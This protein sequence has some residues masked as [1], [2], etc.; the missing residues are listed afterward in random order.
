[1]PKLSSLRNQPPALR[2]ASLP[3][4]SRIRIYQRFS[5]RANSP[6]NCISCSL[7]EKT[8]SRNFLSLENSTELQSYCQQTSSEP[9]PHPSQLSRAAALKPTGSYSPPINSLAQFF[10]MPA[11][12]PL[13]I[14]SL[15][16]RQ[17]QATSPNYN[18]GSGSHNPL[19]FNNNGFLLLF[20]IIA[21]LMVIAT[22]WFFFF[23]KNGGFHWKKGDWEEYKSTVLRRKGP[24]GKTLSNATKSTKLG[25]S[26]VPKFRSEPA[27]TDVESEA[28]DLG[29]VES[30]DFAGY[31][32]DGRKGG[33]RNKDADLAEYKQEKAAKVGGLNTAMTGSH[34]DYSSASAAS[35]AKHAKR[36]KKEQERRE[37]MQK[38][39]D[40]KA[41][42][43]AAKNARDYRPDQADAAS[44]TTYSQQSQQ[45]SGYHYNSY[46]PSQTLRAVPEE[47]RSSSN[48]PRSAERH[49][50]PGKQRGASRPSEADSDTGTKVYPCHIPGLSDR[51]L[52]P[53][54]SVTQIG[55]QQHQPQ[56]Q[57]PK[58]GGGGY[59]RVV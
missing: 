29:R 8:L 51:E 43:Q 33:R 4:T 20:G 52:G 18:P 12:S 26:E 30:R 23:A 14:G 1:M 5:D 10:T 13:E 54:D 48:S 2:F 41:A 34:Y 44:S 16:R 25:M 6:S 28:Y 45:P 32:G 46:R 19:A 35:D 57:S 27:Y 21:A 31:T 38:K 40:A 7:S 15:A 50:G 22:L 47:R 3:A 11:L 9:E 55:A 37:K 39:E 24:D 42:K 53:E 49:H 36:H 59:R 58:K 56:Q 17:N